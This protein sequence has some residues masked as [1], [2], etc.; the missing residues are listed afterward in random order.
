MKKSFIN[1]ISKS[2]WFYLGLI[3][4]LFPI[5]FYNLFSAGFMCWDD[6]DYILENTQVHRFS[7]KEFF[8]R[9]Y[10]GN[11]HPI[12]MLSFSVDWQLFGLHAEGYHIENIFWHLLNSVLV[13]FI[14][15]NLKLSSFFAFVLAF[16]FAF[17]PLQLE[18]VAWIS[19]RKNLLYACFFLSALL[20]YFKYKVSQNFWHLILV[21]VL[22][23]FSLLSKSSAVTFSMI[24]V[25]VDFFCFNEKELKNYKLHFPFFFL[26]IL[27]GLLN[28]V[29][30]SSGKFISTT[31]TYPIIQKVGIFGYGIF[32]YTTTFLFPSKLSIFYA[33]PDDLKVVSIIGI[34]TLLFLT[35][36]FYI[37]I[38][39]KNFDL[40]FPVLFFL[41]NIFLVLQIVPFGDAITADRYMYIP[42]IGLSLLFIKL[43]MKM[44]INQSIIL[45]ILP[46]LSFASISR[47][48][49][50]QDNILLLKNS[51]K[52][53]PT[54][55]IPLN[56]I[57][58]IYTERNDFKNAFFYLNKT[59]NYSPNY[60][61]GYYNRG[62]LNGKIGKYNDA[63]ND[64]T[65]AINLT[66]YY[67]AY[68]GRGNAY[69]MIKDYSKAFLDAEKADG[70]HE[71]NARAKFLLAN[72]YDDLNQIQKSV[73][74]YNQ[75]I[76]L[77]AE[78]PN[79]YLRRAI[80]YGKLQQFNLCL[81]DLDACTTLNKKYAEAYYWK[82]VVKF[83][84]KQNPCNDLKMAVD[85]GFTAA[86]QSLNMYCR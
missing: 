13:F 15:K 81:Q 32:H 24:I 11:Y 49:L 7:I 51:L 86:Q 20:F 36:V 37:L 42:L 62:L 61:K 67:K 65:K 6:A 85:L 68:V 21:Y 23:I 38:K 28:I 19:E 30:Q 58:V 77:N 44:N 80:V 39:R 48:S 34:A 12:T 79:Y 31:H 4:L 27:F 52:I 73:E 55:I 82:G 5:I 8:T 14:G 40:L 25:L 9:F 57:G 59:I 53:N 33:Y 26:S 43:F 60:Y 1:T 29:S 47:A 46:I 16:I 70:L 78:E 22:F 63:I 64:F 75:A 74:Y 35:L 66:S 54:S 45:I 76:L 56:S 3:V 17:H 69:L 18:S 72:C 41:G 2:N 10:I 84:L 71:N 83:N 50:W